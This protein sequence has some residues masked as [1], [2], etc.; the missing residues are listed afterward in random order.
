MNM[1]F[2]LPIQAVDAIV[3]KALQ[4]V[5]KGLAR[6]ICTKWPTA[7]HQFEDVQ[8]WHRYLEAFNVVL[9]YY[10]YPRVEVREAAAQVGV[11]Q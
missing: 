9:E 2:E 6:D 4:E 10:G 11:E 5:A 8:D 3:G 7:P 1:A